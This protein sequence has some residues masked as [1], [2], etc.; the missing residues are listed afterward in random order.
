ME[1]FIK[2]IE[3]ILLGFTIMFF[4]VFDNVLIMWMCYVCGLI[5]EL[6]VH[7]PKPKKI[8]GICRQKPPFIVHS[9]PCSLKDSNASLKVKIM[10][11]K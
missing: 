7:I 5:C 1:L 3:N 9:P 11:E 10:K 8:H 6:G 4:P 2:K